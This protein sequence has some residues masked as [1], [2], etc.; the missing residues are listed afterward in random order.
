MTT[1]APAFPAHGAV[2]IFPCCLFYVADL[3][4]AR[5]LAQSDAHLHQICT[6]AIIHRRSPSLMSP[7]PGSM[8]PVALCDSP[9]ASPSRTVCDRSMYTIS[10]NLPETTK[11]LVIRPEH[12]RL[13]GPPGA[14]RRRAASRPLVHSQAQGQTL[15]AHPN[16]T[17]SSASCVEHFASMEQGACEMAR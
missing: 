10:G 2:G 6:I 12:S 7:S 9:S 3:R 4:Q 1:P 8:T 13:V 16:P 5:H 11:D 14:S 15:A 17:C